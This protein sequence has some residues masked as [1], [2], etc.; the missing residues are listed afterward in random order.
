MEVTEDGDWDASGASQIIVTQAET[1]YVVSTTDD[2]I[3]EPDGSIT[4]RIMPGRGY[5]KG[6]PWARSTDVTDTD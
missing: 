2:D 4:V 3:D 5:S 1:A 6:W